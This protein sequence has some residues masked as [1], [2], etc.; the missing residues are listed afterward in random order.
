MHLDPLENLSYVYVHIL[1]SRI[2][3]QP[4]FTTILAADSARKSYL[5]VTLIIYWKPDYL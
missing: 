3:R 4:K 5:R 1:L 2:H